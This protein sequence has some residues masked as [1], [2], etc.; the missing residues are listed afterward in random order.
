MTFGNTRGN[1]IQTL[2]AQRLGR[3]RNHHFIMDP[4]SQ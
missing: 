1:G 2:A 4:D 3:G